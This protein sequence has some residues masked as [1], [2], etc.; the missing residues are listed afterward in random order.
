[1]LP[2]GMG[3]RRRRGHAPSETHER[4]LAAHDPVRDVRLPAGREAPAAGAEGA[5]EH[6]AVLYFGE[7]DEA[8][9]SHMHC[10]S[11]FSLEWREGKERVRK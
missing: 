3:R 8:V 2:N 4:V 5:V 1:M 10:Q 11:V 7:V 9:W 6:A